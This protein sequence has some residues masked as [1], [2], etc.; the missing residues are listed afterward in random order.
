MQQAKPRIIL[1]HSRLLEDYPS[2]SAISYHGG[3]FYL[4]GDDARSIAILD[5][6]YR[7][8]GAIQLFDYPEKRIPKD[9]KADFETMVIVEAAIQPHLLA[10][11]S[12]SR[13]EREQLMLISLQPPGAQLSRF[14]TGVFTARLRSAGIKEVNIEGA[15]LA[16]ARLLLVNRGNNTYPEN[17]LII[18]GKDY[19][20]H[21]ENAPLSVLP[22]TLPAH[23]GDFLGVS[24][25]CYDALSDTL[26]FTL[27]SEATANAYD[28]GTI[29]DS[30]LAWVD[31]ISQKLEQ[32]VLTL[33]A[34]INLPEADAAFRGRRSKAFV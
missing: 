3:R 23:S 31:R 32:P 20:L 33:D 4:L 24:E 19:W 5:G 10:I 15:A 7:N 16:G 21:Q 1:L 9:R 17:H 22:L 6:D 8:A 13:R 2:G 25:L 26:L 12:A 30:Y 28:D 18:T 27:S 29:G 34:L 14:D 11:G